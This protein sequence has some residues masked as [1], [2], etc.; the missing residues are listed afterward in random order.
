MKLT[1]YRQSSKTRPDGTIVYK[2]ED[3]HPYVDGQLFFV[4]DGLGGAAA[5]R[6]QQFKKELFDVDKILPALFDGVYEEYDNEV[7]VNFVKNSFYELFAVKDCYTDNANNIKKSGYFASRIVT[8]IV[9]HEL[10]YNENVQASKIFTDL[11]AFDDNKKNEYILGLGN[12]FA[13]L[14]KEK[15]SLIANNANL[16]Y[17]SSYSG[18]A[19]LGSTLCATIYLESE[20]SVEAIYLTAGDSRPY[21][22]NELDGLSQILEDEEGVDGG[23]TNYIKANE[24]AQF[25][26]RC[27]YFS[28]SKPC[29]LFNASDGCFDSGYFLSQMAFE[30]LILD[31]IIASDSIE[32]VSESLTNTFLEYGR[33]DDS[34]TIAMRI[35]GFESFEE[36]QKS[37][38][39]RLE[40]LEEEYI[41]QLP[42]LLNVDF[43]AELE[44]CTS[45]YPAKLAEIKSKFESET[46]VTEECTKIVKSGAYAPY[47][48]CLESIAKDIVKAKARIAELET[49][50]QNYIARNYDRFKDYAEKK[51]TWGEKRISA[52]VQKT[53]DSYQEHSAA[54]VLKIQEYKDTFDNVVKDIY[55][56]L[57]NI[58]DIGTPNDFKDYN[59][60]NL[61]IID[62]C[63]SSM[64]E[65]IEFFYSL[66]DKKN[67]AVRKILKERE[68]Y[69]LKNV[70]D[71]KNEPGSCE[72]LLAMILSGEIILD[73]IDL[74][75]DEKEK[76]CSFVEEIATIKSKLM[77]LQDTE[78][79]SRLADFVKQYWEENYMSIIEHMVTAESP[80][81]SVELLEMAKPIIIEMK[82]YS[83]TIK[84]NSELQVC[85][86]EKYESSYM[87]YIG[88]KKS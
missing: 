46:V 37:A 85:L 9:L 33:H 39:K 77:E 75:N 52:K 31:A 51:K 1:V 41:S 47:N 58:Y 81:V 22:W 54:Y 60:L 5:I 76:L 71:T 14:I 30:K 34:S 79:A 62:E 23:M 83:D 57:N 2:G 42:E 26:I 21:I 7:F 63:E 25:H 49:L 16:I 65:L 87:R 50:A 88:G 69:H 10:L 36:L 72:R 27:N 38:Q 12:H 53:Y 13:S 55:S 80:I 18:L 73:D 67:E 8:A 29:I 64:K 35:F 32:G 19:L 3:A 74:F 78:T 4:A 11:K 20:E 70:E 61:Q 43:T 24:D 15:L 28:F 82:N 59:E 17:E 68:K 84:N 40:K 48:E 56:I 44:K 86:F 66:A 45:V 6:H